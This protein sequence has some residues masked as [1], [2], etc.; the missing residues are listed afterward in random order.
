[1][2]E[3]WVADQVFSKS[4][5]FENFFENASGI[6]F[7]HR[8]FAFFV[9]AL[10]IIV[11]YKSNKLNLTKPQYNGITLLIYGI[12][13]QFLLG[14]FT[15]IY[16]VPLLLGVLHQ[17]GAFFLFVVCIFLVHQFTYKKN[18]LS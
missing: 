14:I 17:T 6:Q 16:Q 11:W 7:V 8:T 15:L 18:N 12:T 5:F 3:S 13:I 9:V 1:M 2:G 10:V 4:S